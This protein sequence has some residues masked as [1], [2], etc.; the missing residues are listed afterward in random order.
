LLTNLLLDWLRASAPAR[1]ITVA[2]QAHRGARLEPSDLIRPANWTPLSAY[3]RSKAC[4]ILFTR[5][6]ARRPMRKRSPPRACIRGRRTA[7]GDR[8]GTLAG[9]AGG[10]PSR[11]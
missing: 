10:S 11:F 4:N 8:A 6:L 5:A 1:V 2:S 7:I 3:S 9:W